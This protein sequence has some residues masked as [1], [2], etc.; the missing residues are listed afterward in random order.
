MSRPI[1]SADEVA[2]L[3]AA[4]Q[5]TRWALAV[6][7]YGPKMRGDPWLGDGFGWNQ[8]AQLAEHAGGDDTYGMKAQFVSLVKKAGDAKSINEGY[9]PY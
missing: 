4:P 8:I 5:S 6:A 9:D 1:S 3:D 2:S 7:A